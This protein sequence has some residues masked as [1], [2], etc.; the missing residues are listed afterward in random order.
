MT[1]M[2]PYGVIGWERLY[3]FHPDIH[4][5]LMHTLPQDTYNDPRHDSG[6]VAVPLDKLHFLICEATAVA[7]RFGELCL[8][9]YPILM[10]LSCQSQWL[11]PSTWHVRVTGPEPALK[12]FTVGRSKS[13]GGVY[14]QH[15]DTMTGQ[16][17]V[18]SQYTLQLG[19]KP[20]AA[21]AV[22]FKLYMESKLSSGIVPTCGTH[23]CAVHSITRPGGHR[24]C[25]QHAQEKLQSL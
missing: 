12:S 21:M 13:A 9:L 5:E 23:I 20:T 19:Y 18:E 1:V 3:Q 24:A 8:H 10:F 11:P 4:L 16:W 25:G 6:W 7:M 2:T 17:I 15:A 22:A 14:S